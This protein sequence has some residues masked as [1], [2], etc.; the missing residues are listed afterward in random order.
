[1]M[2]RNQSAHA[3]PLL[4]GRELKPEHK[5]YLTAR[6]VSLD[7]A[8]R[9]GLVSVFAN[10]AKEV[11]DLG[12]NDGL[13]IPYPGADRFARLRLDKPFKGKNGKPQRYMTPKG[14][15]VRP[16]LS[17]IIADVWQDAAQ[18]LYIVEGPIK[19]LALIGVGLA[20]IGL[21]GVRT[22]HQKGAPVSR[23]HDEVFAKVKLSHRRVVILFDA[24]KATNKDVL[25][26]EK[27]QAELYAA[28]G[29]QVF[30]ATLPLTDDGKDQGPDDFLAARG[31][32]ALTAIIDAAKPFQEAYP[33]EEKPATKKTQ[34]QIVVELMQESGALVWFDNQGVMW[35]TFEV[36]DH[37]E[38]H[39]LRSEAARRYLRQLTHEKAGIIPGAQSVQ[40]A[41]A[42]LE[43]ITPRAEP[44]PVFVRIGEKEGKLYLDLGSH[45]W[46]AIEIDSEG[47]RWVKVPP[48]RFRRSKGMVAIPT[49]V[50]GG[51]LEELRS[52][53]NTP[54]ETEW[55][56]ALAWVLA[57]LRAKGPYPIAILQGEQ[58]CAKST[59]ARMLRS[60]V[61]PNA[62]ALRTS[63]RNEQDLAIAASNGWVVA[64]D[65]LS[66]VSDWLSDALCRAA[67]GGGFATRALYSN[68]EETLLE[69]QRPVLLNG[70]DEVATRGDLADRAL[71]VTL[72]RIEED[73][74]KEESE[75]WRD[76]EEA[77][78]RILGAL[79]DV[80]SA[81]LK[82]LP[83]ITAKRLPRMAD[84]AKWILACEEALGWAPE[85]F[86]DAYL[87]A[88]NQIAE[89]AVD[90]DLFARSVVE[91]IKEKEEWKG[92]ASELLAEINKKVDESERRIK[93]WPQDATRLSNKLRRLAPSLRRVGVIIDS[94]HREGGTGRRLFLLR[95]CEASEAVTPAFQLERN[96]EEKEKGEETPSFRTET[97]NSV[98]S[99]TSLTDPT[100]KG[101]LCEAN[102]R[103][104]PHNPSQPHNSLTANTLESQHCDASEASDAKIHTHSKKAPALD[105]NDLP[106]L[107]NTEGGFEYEI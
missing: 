104:Q 43:A 56:F 76:F 65:N 9:A 80:V 55:R 79:L 28:A 106:K 99:V 25:A 101:D 88:R 42:T 20:A 37:L 73:K 48:V 17:P 5:G 105:L 30:I 52:F 100:A 96:R 70:I 82:K 102:V 27:K 81:G 90:G 94:E 49:P 14:E 59:T 6:A 26:A 11:F 107:L 58:G 35:C 77:R 103:L 46:S 31:V 85:S 78:P 2:M 44:F 33:P 15:D 93:G 68:D 91:F 87:G 54:Q 41:I 32:E 98:T 67:T 22:G 53:L 36:D 60:L 47:W 74:R 83:S 71:L 95:I 89:T 75:V 50:K 61:D 10:E 64:Y 97:Q 8:K 12:H 66:G 69:F 21:A 3:D 92:T 45:D 40:D 84:F 24:G 86:L 29:A 4:V 19:A 38:H 16:Y 72:P 39:R 57:A 62:C 18:P 63:P 13:L 7:I 23:L 34:A 51:V 1:M